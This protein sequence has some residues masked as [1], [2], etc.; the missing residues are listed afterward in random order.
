MA[1]SPATYYLVIY[2]DRC[3]LCCPMRTERVYGVPDPGIIK[4]SISAEC[5]TL[6]ASRKDARAAINRTRRHAKLWGDSDHEGLCR[7]LRVI[8]AEVAHA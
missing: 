4:N 6:F 5:A 2:D 8:K 1:D 7:H 3:D